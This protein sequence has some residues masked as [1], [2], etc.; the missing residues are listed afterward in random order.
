MNS[1]HSISWSYRV[2]T[3]ITMFDPDEYHYAALYVNG[4]LVDDFF[5]TRGWQVRRSL[6]KAI[7]RAAKGLIT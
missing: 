1:K 7:R 3:G 6:R 5:G 2:D 4:S